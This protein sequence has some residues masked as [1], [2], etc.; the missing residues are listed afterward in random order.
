MTRN[1]GSVSVFIAT[2]SALALLSPLGCTS[3][4]DS[5]GSV[6]RSSQ[7]AVGDD[8]GVDARRTDARVTDARLR[9]DGRQDVAPADSAADGA[10][11]D[12]SMDDGPAGKYDVRD[13]LGDIPPPFGKIPVSINFQKP[14]TVTPTGYLP[15]FGETFN[16]RGNGYAYGWD[17]DNTLA[18]RERMDPQSPS[19]AYDTLIHLQKAESPMAYWEIAVPNGTYFVRIVSGDPPNVDGHFQLLVEGTTVLDGSP[20]DEERWFIGSAKVVVSD[21]RLTVTSGPDAVNNKINFIEI[22]TMSFPDGGL[23]QRIDSAPLPPEVDAA[24]AVVVK[25]DSGAAG[26]TGSAGTGG[27]TTVPKKLDSSVSDPVDE[28]PPAV[29]PRKS[30][31]CQLGGA[32]DAAPG[33]MLLP[34]LFGAALLRRRRRSA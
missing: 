14:E 18:A 34:I 22:S 2:A 21:K 8:A 9:L 32:S 23:L 33:L 26:S 30:G 12:A 17:I 24:P 16:D 10:A 29:K 25:L 7:A 1:I 5:S 13:T 3:S 19:V 28:E 11:D 27:T 4:T 20:S 15:D 31:G 6:Q